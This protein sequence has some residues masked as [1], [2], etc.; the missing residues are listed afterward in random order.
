MVM[1]RCYHH[2]SHGKGIEMSR[3][4]ERIVGVVVAIIMAVIVGL[5]SYSAGWT[6]GASAMQ[7]SADAFK[8]LCDEAQVI[9]LAQQRE[10]RSLRK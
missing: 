3:M 2:F 10:I 8:S 7:E 1:V 5:M 6:D 9:M 4:D